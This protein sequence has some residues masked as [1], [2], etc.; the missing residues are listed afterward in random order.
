MRRAWTTP[1]LS[2]ATAESFPAAISPTD[3]RGLLVFTVEAWKYGVKSKIKVNINQKKY[4]NSTL[5]VNTTH[6]QHSSDSTGLFVCNRSHGGILYN[7]H[8]FLDS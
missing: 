1:T 8:F 2:A 5:L 7:L 6:V 3:T 4:H